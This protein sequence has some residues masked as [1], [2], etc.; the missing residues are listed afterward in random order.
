M[1]RKTLAVAVLLGSSFLLYQVTYSHYT[2]HTSPNSCCNATPTK[3]NRFDNL[4][5]T[6]GV[7]SPTIQELFNILGKPCPKDLKDLNEYAQREW[8][9]KEG[10]ERWDLDQQKLDQKFMPVFKKLGLIDEIKPEKKQ[11]EYAFIMGA[12]AERMK[13]RIAYL[14]KLKNEG[15]VFNH[16]VLLAGLRPANAIKEPE[17]VGKT[18]ADIMMD[19]Y[20]K[21]S[22]PQDRVQLVCAPMKIDSSGLP[23]I[24]PNTDDTI[25][26]FKDSEQA[27]AHQGS[28][29][30]ISNSPFIPRPVSLFRM[31]LPHTFD[32]YGAGDAANED[33]AMAVI[34]DE[35][36]RLIFAELKLFNQLHQ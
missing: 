22:L 18:E 1:V 17:W 24:R 33:I 10:V 12:L 19:L 21:S 8:I 9:R 35:L 31:L 34:F 20:K 14:E 32:I 30:V 25:L 2:K 13:I 16:I 15:Y 7:P 36:A 26:A 4:I 11:F 23:T 6:N 27:H 5:H 29:V 28:C 3:S